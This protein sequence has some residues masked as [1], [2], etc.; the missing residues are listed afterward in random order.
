MVHHHYRLIW[1]FQIG[2]NFCQ[3]L[4]GLWQFLF[5]H[6]SSSLSSPT[7][8]FTCV[9]APACAWWQADPVSPPE[10]RPACCSGARCCC[11]LFQPASASVIA[12]TILIID[13]HGPHCHRCHRCHRCHHWSA[14]PRQSWYEG[15]RC[16][17]RSPS[18]GFS[19]QDG[20]AQPVFLLI[21][22]QL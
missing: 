21:F 19:S 3:L 5:F 13:Y 9:P 14:P 16:N 10:L 12:I 15:N 22:L 11:G 8:L 1:Y 6:H 18:C 17:S 2:F 7:C 4:F 20:F